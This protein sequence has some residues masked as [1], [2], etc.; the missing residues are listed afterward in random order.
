MLDSSKITIC[1]AIL[2]LLLVMTF[3]LSLIPLFVKS[4]IDSD[5]VIISMFISVQIVLLVYAALV[6]VF[7]IYCKLTIDKENAD[8]YS[9]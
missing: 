8:P 3:Y 2:A 1:F 6:A 7:S 4:S 9:L 5:T